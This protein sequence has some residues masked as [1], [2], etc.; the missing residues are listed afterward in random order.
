MLKY[1]EMLPGSNAGGSEGM[2]R[3]GDFVLAA[4]RGRGFL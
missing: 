3:G 2:F 4:V 1:F